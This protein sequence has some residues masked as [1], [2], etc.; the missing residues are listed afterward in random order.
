MILFAKL[1]L[2]VRQCDF[3]RNLIVFDKT[4]SSR[5]RL[6]EMNSEVREIIMPLCKGKRPDDYVWL[7]PKP[8]AA[9]TVSEWIC[10][11]RSG[12]SAQSTCQNLVLRK[13]II[14]ITIQPSLSR[15]GLS[16]HRMVYQDWLRSHGRRFGES[17]MA[18]PLACACLVAWRFGESSQP[19]K[20][21]V[22]PARA[23]SAASRE[24]SMLRI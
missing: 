2:K 14:R 7:N 20:T 9:R 13:R 16:N 21:F 12:V 11:I 19:D 8:N 10:G 22:I 17:E 1:T 6:V 3:F 24:P 4:K 18:C 23:D 5:P 15:F